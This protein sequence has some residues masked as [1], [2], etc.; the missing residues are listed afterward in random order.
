MFALC[1]VEA[2]STADKLVLK[3]RSPPSDEVRDH[4]GQQRL[5]KAAM[6]PPR[7]SCS[8]Q[9]FVETPPASVPRFVKTLTIGLAVR[10]AAAAF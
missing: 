7:L 5:R 6:N 2:G 8:M 3:Q 4:G 1:S 10:F 9:T